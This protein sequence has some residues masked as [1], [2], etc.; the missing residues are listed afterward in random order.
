MSTRSQAHG[1]FLLATKPAPPKELSGRLLLRLGYALLTFHSHGLRIQRGTE[2][3][4]TT[5]AKQR[6]NPIPRSA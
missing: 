6:L 3:A 2:P 4:I 1:L 5:T